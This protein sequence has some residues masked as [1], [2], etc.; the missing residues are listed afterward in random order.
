MAQY[1]TTGEDLTSIANAIRAKTGENS[2]LV[3]PTGFVTAINS[4]STPTDG[5][6]EN[7]ELVTTLLNDT[8]LLKDTGFATWTPSS[9]ASVILSGQELTGQELDLA[10]YDYGCIY[11]INI[12]YE[13]VEGTTVVNGPTEG[14]YHSVVFPFKRPSSLTDFNQGRRV[15]NTYAAIE[16]GALL[17]KYTASTTYL[18]YSNTAIYNSMSSPSTSNSTSDTPTYTFKTPT[19]RAATNANAFTAEMAAAL[20]QNNTT[21]NRKVVLYRYKKNTTLSN[22][23]AQNIVNAFTTI[24]DT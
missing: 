15:Q 4:I 6:G 17:Y 16:M 3:Y 8:V 9:T 1:L 21:I 18:S 7:P 2:P 22:I 14:Y 20:D 12:Q 23:M 11:D 10:N 24:H 13:Y 19:M 5:Y